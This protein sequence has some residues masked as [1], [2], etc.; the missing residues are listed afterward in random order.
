MSELDP[1]Q[2]SN[3]FDKQDDVRDQL[4]ESE[5]PQEH[6]RLYLN[7]DRTTVRVCSDCGSLVFN[8]DKHDEFH[9]NIGV[10]G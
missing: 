8:I 9:E 1:R 4:S 5:Q 6:V 2:G 10:I 3:V 7:W